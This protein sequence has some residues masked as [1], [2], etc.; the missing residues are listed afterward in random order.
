MLGSG[1][2]A[3]TVASA[4]SDGMVPVRLV[5]ALTSSESCT[6]VTPVEVPVLLLSLASRLS[7]EALA[8][9]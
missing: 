9:G 3:A 7:M 2:C 1:D 5:P 8:S 4:E 6:L